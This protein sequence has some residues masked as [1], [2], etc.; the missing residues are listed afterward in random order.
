MSRF[1]NEGLLLCSFS[2]FDGFVLVGFP[3]MQPNLGA[4]EVFRGRQ[5]KVES[6][7][8]HAQYKA[9]WYRQLV[10]QSC[11]FRDSWT[12]WTIHVVRVATGTISIIYSPWLPS[13]G[14]SFELHL[15]FHSSS[16]GGYREN[17]HVC[18]APSHPR[19]APV[20]FELPLASSRFSNSAKVTGNLGCCIPHWGELSTSSASSNTLT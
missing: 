10:T 18:L 1:A 19:P 14:S 17:W 4:N 6:G 11:T 13:D 8:E 15:G 7:K 2:C 3:L 5:G 16:K 12:W 9:P 20:L